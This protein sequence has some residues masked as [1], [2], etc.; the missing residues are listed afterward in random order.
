MVLRVVLPYRGGLFS[1]KIVDVA[2]TGA[3]FG[4]REHVLD[5]R[6]GCE[7]F[8]RPGYN[9]NLLSV[10]LPALGGGVAKLERGAPVADVGCGHGSST[11]LMAAAFPNSAF[12]GS[13]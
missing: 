11:I 12:T 13:D 1:P 10:W 2:R 8:F 5:V 6:E 7:R 9:A 4:G 3:G